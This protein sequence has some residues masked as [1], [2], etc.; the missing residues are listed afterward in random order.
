MA[1]KLYSTGIRYVQQFITEHKSHIN[2]LL[3]N[4]LS[5]EYSKIFGRSHYEI[6]IQE[7]IEAFKIDKDLDYAVSVLN[8]YKS[9]TFIYELYRRLN[10]E[11]FE[12]PKVAQMPLH[13]QKDMHKSI[14]YT[15]V[16]YVQSLP[17]PLHEEIHKRLFR[18]Y[19]LHML[20]MV[21]RKSNL[22]LDYQKLCQ[23]LLK[24]K[25]LNV[26]ESFHT[27]EDKAVFKLFLSGR[28]LLQME[29]KSLKTLR[30]K[31]YK[32][33]FYDLLDEKIFIPTD[34]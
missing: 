3:Q 4:P 31:A 19:F 10:L 13:A 6:K 5:F 8:N 26:K 14:F 34:T 25:Q 29:G 2:A 16:F 11:R 7:F 32:K 33:L 30:K 20:M 15:F 18:F 12:T 9:Y 28:E 23:G 21:H 22:V 24:Q 1:K 27:Q 17:D